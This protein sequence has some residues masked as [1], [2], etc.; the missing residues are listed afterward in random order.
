MGHVVFGGRSSGRG[1]ISYTV[2]GLVWPGASDAML[3]ERDVSLSFKT[4]SHELINIKH[5]YCCCCCCCMLRHLA[6]SCKV[7]CREF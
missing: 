4:S 6:R 5:R 1:Q 3:T 7:S 2:S